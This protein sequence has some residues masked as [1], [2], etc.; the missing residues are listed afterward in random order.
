M[1]AN[2]KSELREQATPR[3]MFGMGALLVI[4]IILGLSELARINQDLRQEV[5]NLQR[6]MRIEQ[7]LLDDASLTTRSSD[8]AVSLSDMQS[9]F[10]TG[11][12]P[13][14]V[15]AQIQTE[16][17][18]VANNAELRNSRITVLSDPIALGA[19]AQLFEAN[20]RINDR[21]GQFLALFQ[22]LARMDGLVV[23]TGFQWRRRNRNAELQMVAP[24]LIG[25]QAISR[26]A[27]DA[28]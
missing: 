20:M 13:G 3:A 28:S 1:F 22:E 7:A 25:E 8:I 23:V 26:P 27:E 14:I 21:Q 4:L 17:G 15:R 10:W 24:A 12:T 18:R 6:A 5:N 11:S 9:Q 16:L 2:L 19:D